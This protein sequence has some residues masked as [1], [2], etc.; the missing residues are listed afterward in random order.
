MNQ[1]LLIVP[2]Q[3][4]FN[5]IRDNHL[6]QEDELLLWGKVNRIDYGLHSSENSP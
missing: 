1:A 2:N 6:S 3:Y 4:Y 5:P